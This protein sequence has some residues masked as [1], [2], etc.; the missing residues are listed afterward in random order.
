MRQT[1]SPSCNSCQIVPHL[2]NKTFPNQQSKRHAAFIVFRRPVRPSFDLHPSLDVFISASGFA[3]SLKRRT[4]DRTHRMPRAVRRSCHFAESITTVFVTWKQLA[5]TRGRGERGVNCP[6]WKQNSVMSAVRRCRAKLHL[7]VRRDQINRSSGA[8][9]G[10]NTELICYTW[11]TR[12]TDWYIWRLNYCLD[13]HR[14]TRSRKMEKQL[15]IFSVTEIKWTSCEFDWQVGYT[16]VRVVTKEQAR[17]DLLIS[18]SI[19]SSSWEAAM[20]SCWRT[21][22]LF[23]I[24]KKRLSNG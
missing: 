16:E 15:N 20:R 24:V 23:Q 10:E 12:S 6:S 2:Y 21:N 17:N 1:N 9:C 19:M 7:V 18:L 14:S 13:I 11:L 4:P 8:D 5:E 3:S 22:F